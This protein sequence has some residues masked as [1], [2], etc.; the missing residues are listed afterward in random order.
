MV[1]LEIFTSD[2]I[3][4]NREHLVVDLINAMR[5]G[6]DILLDMRLEGPDLDSIGL[7]NLLKTLCESMR[8]DCKKITITTCNMLDRTN[9][10][11]PPHHFVISTRQSLKS[12]NTQ[13]QIINPFGCFIGRSNAPRL[14]LASYLWT[15]YR[16]RTTLTFHYDT[17]NDFH[18]NNLG[19]QDLINHYGLEFLP[20]VTEFLLQ[21]P[22]IRDTVSYPIVQQQHCNLHDAYQDFLVEICCE[23]YFTGETF[24]PTEKT[25]RAVAMKTPFIIQGPRYFLRHL[26]ELGFQTFDRWW[27]EGY[28][29]DPAD[30]QPLQIINVL[31][32]LS[33]KSISELELMLHQMQPIL[34][35]N[36]DLLMAMTEQQWKKLNV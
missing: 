23:T 5:S 36:H 13:K 3:I 32:Q 20:D 30:L 19:I 1:K 27:D 15:H 26:R 11:T 28:S 2:C 4:W 35:H 7:N 24:F 8:Y 22:I 34:D 16:D 29:D 6:E 25:W 17:D 14:L 21:C 33:K 12:V 9:S 10:L 31:D 18:R